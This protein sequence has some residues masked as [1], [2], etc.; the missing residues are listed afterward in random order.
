M[1][2]IFEEKQK[3]ETAESS[4][5]PKKTAAEYQFFFCMLHAQNM[6]EITA[7]NSNTAAVGGMCFVIGWW[8]RPPRGVCVLLAVAQLTP[9]IFGVMQEE[10]SFCL[11]LGKAGRVQCLVEVQT[12]R[13]GLQKLSC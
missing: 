3:I 2:H 13:D 12:K 8:I 10:R 5:A 9:C 4:K 6:P 11:L 7:V 1:Y